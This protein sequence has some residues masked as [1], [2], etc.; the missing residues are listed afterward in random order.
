MN[1]NDTT[2]YEHIADLIRM[3]IS[4]GQDMT[5]EERHQL[6]VVAGAKHALAMIREWPDSL[7]DVKHRFITMRSHRVAQD[8]SKLV[9]EIIGP[10]F[11]V[12]C[13]GN[14]IFVNVN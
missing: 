9:A 8:A 11:Q 10:R 4:G 3:K 2:D 7:D 14:I 13:M 6:R 1:T 12:K 5:A